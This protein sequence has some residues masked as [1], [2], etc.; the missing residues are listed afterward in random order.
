MMNK[1]RVTLVL[2]TATTLA[3][4]SAVMAHHGHRKYMQQMPEHHLHHMTRSHDTPELQLRL[5]MWHGVC[6]CSVH[7]AVAERH[8]I[9]QTL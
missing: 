2:I 4:G 5:C 7:L 6:V 9:V 3:V 1:R 8:R